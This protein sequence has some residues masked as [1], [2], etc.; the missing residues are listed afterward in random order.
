MYYIKKYK[1]VSKDSPFDFEE[2]YG[3][4]NPYDLSVMLRI[5]TED[6]RSCIADNDWIICTQEKQVEVTVI[7]LNIL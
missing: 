3:V 1:I 4:G 7:L 2:Q 5:L 6:I